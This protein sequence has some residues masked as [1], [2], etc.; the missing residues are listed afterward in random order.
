MIERLL[1]YIKS[2]RFWAVLIIAVVGF[3]QS[4]GEITPNLADLIYTILGGY[5]GIA[6][7]DKFRK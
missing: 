2:T 1:R 3:L 7:I 5:V 4:E 6:T